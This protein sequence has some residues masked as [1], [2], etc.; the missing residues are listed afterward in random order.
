M[1][2]EVVAKGEITLECHIVDATISTA[3]YRYFRPVLL[4]VKSKGDD[5][6]TAKSLSEDLFV[7]MESVSQKLLEICVN[8]EM[9]ERVS[10]EDRFVINQRGR[11][12]IDDGMVLV[13]DTRRMWKIYHTGCELVPAIHR[14]LMLETGSYEADSQ[15]DEDSSA[16]YISNEMLNLEGNIMEPILGKNAAPFRIEEFGIKYEKIVQADV[17]VLIHLH[18]A[19]DGVWLVF[20][21]YK[22]NEKIMSKKI[23]SEK[24]YGEVIKNLYDDEYGYQYNMQWDEEA[25]SGT[26]R[27][28]GSI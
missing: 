5:G 11:E 19:R 16:D 17:W 28:A 2:K 21:A 24:T 27:H 14:V 23:K 6:A 4:H 20:V 12:S 1:V 22:D 18:L 15:E 26:R 13:K 3:M 8:E 9:V 25:C 7:G 10:E